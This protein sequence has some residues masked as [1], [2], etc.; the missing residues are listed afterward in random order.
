MTQKHKRKTRKKDKTSSCPCC[1]GERYKTEITFFTSFSEKYR[2]DW[3]QCSNRAEFSEGGWACDVCI[4]S[5]KAMIANPDK[6]N[7]GLGG[8]HFAYFDKQ[9]T[10]VTCG[11]AFIFSKEEQKY[12]YEEL[13]FIVYSEAK[14]CLKCRKQRQAIT[15][16]NTKI[17]K[18]VENLA[19]N[20]PQE[21]EDLIDLYLEIKNLEKAKYYF[22]V[23]RK[24]VRKDRHK[25]LMMEL[26]ARIQYK[27]DLN[28]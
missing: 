26:L 1:K 6:Q 2:N 12:W 18:L 23:L 25:P 3:I 4:D 13:G 10:C 14:E 17:G 9:K 15:Y 16:R 27:I 24:K 5:G 8:A 20:S 22:A 7:F 21:M 11:V 19:N 28:K